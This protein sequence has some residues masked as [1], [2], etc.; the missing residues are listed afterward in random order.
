MG[1]TE[2]Q[3]RL[4][5]EF[6]GLDTTD[7]EQVL[8]ALGAKL[9]A[10]HT[11]PAPIV[12][13]AKEPIKKAHDAPA[14][15][16]G[17]PTRGLW[18]IEFS[19]SLLQLIHPLNTGMAYSIVKG[20]L[21]AESRNGIVAEAL[22]RQTDALF[23]LD[24]DVIFPDI[25]LYRMWNILQRHPEAAAVTAVYATKMEPSEPLIYADDRSGAFWDWPLGALI[26]IHS[27][28]AGCQ[29]VRMSYVAK[30]SPPWFN[31][32]VADVQGE[33]G[34]YRQR[35]GHDRYFHIRLR[36]EAGGVVYA[37]TGLLCS[38]WDTQ[39]HRNFLLPPDAP[40]FQKDLVGEAYV[41]GLTDGVVSWRRLVPVKQSN[42]FAGYLDWV[43]QQGGGGAGHREELIPT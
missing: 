22:E 36:E 6:T 3:E 21:P 15:T 42:T 31:D 29:L 30:L 41:P 9:E 37:D 40:C 20:R 16:I 24:D 33:T 19:M 4:V 13:R 11:P 18:P 43:Q 27:G 10:A 28:G 7:P 12:Y 14:I 23:L 32:T 39:L 38:H 1:L 26:P 17:I 5:R 8:A 35:W 25:T 2:T 34:R